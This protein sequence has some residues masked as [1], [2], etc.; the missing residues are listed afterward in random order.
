MNVSIPASIGELTNLKVLR[1]Y[2][3]LGPGETGSSVPVAT[4]NIKPLQQQSQ[5]FK[6]L[7]S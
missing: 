7:K 6:I 5:N 2:G 3:A 1:L 4:A